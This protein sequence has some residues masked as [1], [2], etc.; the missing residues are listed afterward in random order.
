MRWGG[1]GGEACENS[2]IPMIA[3]A[4]TVFASDFAKR[5]QTLLVITAAAAT[6]SGVANASSATDAIGAIG[7]EAAALASA[8]WPIV[9]AVVL[10]MIGMKL[11]KKF[12]YKAS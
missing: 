4:L 12:A 9:T 6:A 7:T 2:T 11:F 1:L 8:A 5:L 3:N 10:S